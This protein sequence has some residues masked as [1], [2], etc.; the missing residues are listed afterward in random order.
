MNVETLQ[1]YLVPALFIG[2]LIWRSRRFKKVSGKISELLKEG[3][4][5]VDVR[6]PGEFA[7]GAREGSINIPLNELEQGASRLDP[8]KTVV[9]CCAS[10]T[11]SAM[12][13][14]ILK[15]KGFKNVVN[16][17]P[18]QNTLTADKT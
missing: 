16:A 11:R 9:L 7:S 17:G 14:S 12:A 5:V 8:A 13:A 2:F 10:G 4:V 18:W 6:S 3:A 1:Q 15:R